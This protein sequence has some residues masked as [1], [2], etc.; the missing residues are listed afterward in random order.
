M[1]RNSC[2]WLL[3]TAKKQCTV[4]NGWLERQQVGLL[5]FFWILWTLDI[6]SVLEQSWKKVYSRATTK[7]ILLLQPEHWFCRENKPERGRAQ[8]W[9]PNKKM[10][11]AMLRIVFLVWL[12]DERH[13]ALFPA[14]TI[15]RDRYHRKS[16]IRH[17]QVLNLRRTWVQ[18]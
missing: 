7:S 8:D 17:K 15:V 18:A 16:P 2:K 1:G 11:V 3:W 6:Y 4:Y 9:Y 10:V 12:T 13:L 5:S 14:G